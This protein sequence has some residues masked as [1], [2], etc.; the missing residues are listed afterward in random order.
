MATSGIKE[1][2][3][4]PFKKLLNHVY[5]VNG[6]RSSINFCKIIKLINDLLSK[7]PNYKYQNNIERFCRKTEFIF[8]HKDFLQKQR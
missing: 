6:L 2:L 8:L 7:R 4:V 3:K 5:F 1:L